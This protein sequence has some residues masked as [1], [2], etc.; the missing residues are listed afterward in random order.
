MNKEYIL[1][2][3]QLGDS[4]AENEPGLSDYFIETDVWRRLENGEVDI[5]Y[6]SKGTGKSALYRLLLERDKVFYNQKKSWL[7][8]VNT[9][10]K[11]LS[12]KN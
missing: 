11:I 4:V 5:I 8:R 1:S 9:L 7:L 6:G 3:L 10:V 12:S 2:N